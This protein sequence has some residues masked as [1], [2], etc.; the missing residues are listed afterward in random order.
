MNS[1]RWRKFTKSE[2]IGA[3]GAE[4]MR[5]SV[6]EGKDKEKVAASF[7]RAISLVDAAIGDPRW[8]ALIHMLLVLRDDIAEL[9]AG[10]RRNS[11]AVYNAL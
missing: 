10:R 11:V 7:E 2:Q 9:Y 8:H 5:A 4:L 3:I 1:E 6:W